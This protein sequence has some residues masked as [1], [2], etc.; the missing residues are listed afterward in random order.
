MG[1]I[2]TE[3]FFDVQK[4]VLQTLEDKYYSPFL[5]SQY[6]QELKNAL[7]V[8]DIKD[9]SII[10]GSFVDIVDNEHQSSTSSTANSS[11][12]SDVTT[13]TA[14]DFQNHST[15]AKTKLDQLQVHN[16]ISFVLIFMRHFQFSYFHA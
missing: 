4:T 6:Y 10:G 2:G 15:Y 13:T 14:I 3:I 7:T 9:M 12:D 8:E 11:T 16:S 5:S 1:D